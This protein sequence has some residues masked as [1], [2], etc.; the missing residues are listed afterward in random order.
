VTTLELLMALAARD[1]MR[2]GLMRQMEE[3]GIA[4]ILMPVCGI[5]AFPHHQREADWLDSMAPCTVWNLLGMPGL[6]IPFGIAADGL[7]VG[8]QIVGRPWDEEVILDIGVRL[9]Q[10][11]GLLPSPPGY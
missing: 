9:E 5:T 8:V 7:P 6:A 1:R 11:R 2:A 3:A 4:A 10:A